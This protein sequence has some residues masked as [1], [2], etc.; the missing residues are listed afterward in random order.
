[1]RLD[2]NEGWRG[3][4][5]RVTAA[6]REFLE[7]GHLNR[8]PD[9]TARRLRRAIARYAG[10]PVSGVQVF[11]GADA[12][13][14][15]LVRAFVSPGGH[16]VISAPC[17][18]QFRMLAEAAGGSVELVY[19][20][21]PFKADVRSLAARITPSTRLV[22]LCN[23]N[24]PTGR[25][26]RDSDLRRLQAA[27][28]DGLLIVD[29]AYYEFWG[30]TAAPLIDT[31]PRLAVVRSFS[32]AFCLAAVRCGYV[33]ASR[34]VIAAL[35]RRRNG[36]DV[37]ALAQVAALAALEDLGFMRE[38]V[39]MMQRN[40]AALVADLRA[41][42]WRVVTTPANFILV[43]CDDPTR[44]VAKL[45]TLGIDVRDRSCL[46]QLERF[47]RV[48]IGTGEECRRLVAALDEVA[49]GTRWPSS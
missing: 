16:V 27:V 41:H 33:L 10:R 36:K 3:P 46:G 17:Y 49:E 43:E 30:R 44:L 4:S 23:P 38:S 28:G 11:N 40:R 15:C 24:N 20:A 45:R 6:L 5:P 26:F 9:P 42:G 18:D 14:D 39:A 37:N 13:L 34:D 12:A 8:Y 35:N 1:V 47:V 25:T 21:S 48:S 32:K 2:W 7:G 22:Y 31:N 19:G 29:E